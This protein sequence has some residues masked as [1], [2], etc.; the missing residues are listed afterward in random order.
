[1]DDV[2][3]RLRDMDRLGIDVQVL[4][5][6]IF[7]EQ[8]TERPEV[9][10]AICRAWNRWLADIW[11][12]SKGRLRWC[13]V[14]PLLSLPDALDEMRFAK[15]NGAVAVSIRPLEGRHLI[16]DPCFYPIYEEASRLD[17]AMGLH[18]ANGNPQMCDLLRSPYDPSTG[19]ALF[20]APAVMACY[21]LIMSEIPQ[22]FP[23]LRWGVIEASAQ[24][25][26]WIVHE[27]RERYVNRGRAF[28]DNVFRD[29]RIFVTCQTNDDLPYV[30][31]YAGGRN[32]LI[33]TDYGHLDPAT[34]V[35]AITVLRSTAELPGDVVENILSTNPGELYAID[36]TAAPT[37][38]RSLTAAG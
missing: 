17:L 14:P 34:E 15:Q 25:I 37:W 27:A 38:D 36:P 11:K 2:E 35:D 31:K 32:L 28:P 20:R 5:N 1:M 24:W 26:P 21:S 4:Y 7:I 30:L 6:T 18:I 12:Q 33:G 16:V 19:L 10:A 8:L 29:Y 22:V 13:M 3:L 23:N 9:D